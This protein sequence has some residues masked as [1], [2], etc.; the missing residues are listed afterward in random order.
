MT[1][2]GCKAKG[3]RAETEFVAILN[4]LGV[5]SQRVVGSGA[6]KGAPSD[7]KIGVDSVDSERDETKSIYR[8]EVKNRATNPEYLW[9]Q[10]ESLDSF[11]F[12][13]S[14]KQGPEFLWN[15][16]NQDIST[17]VLVLRRAKVPVGTLKNKDYNQAYM[18][19]MGI[20]DFVDLVKKAY[21]L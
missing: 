13:L 21:G 8:A 1:G 17:K 5:P 4:E 6:M 3:N 12:V 9:S 16:Y 7:V 14:A 2:K 15:Y 11:G 20:E 18:I 19:C 10:L